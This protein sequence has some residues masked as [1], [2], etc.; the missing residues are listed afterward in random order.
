[1]P[2]PQPSTQE[3]LGTLKEQ[4]NPVGLDL[5]RLRSVPRPEGVG[6]R[7]VTGPKDLFFPRR[8]AQPPG[9]SQTI[10]GKNLRVNPEGIW[11]ESR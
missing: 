5:R 1:M 4:V 2:H 3:A 7:T 6:F 10:W 8:K 11:Q 9:D